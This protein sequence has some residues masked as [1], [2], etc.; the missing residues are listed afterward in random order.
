MADP[1]AGDCKGLQE[2]LLIFPFCQFD[3]F[4]GCVVLSQFFCIFLK[5]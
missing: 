1:D 4:P 5:I 2:L 3:I